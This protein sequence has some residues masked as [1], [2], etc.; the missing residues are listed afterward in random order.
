MT[1]LLTMTTTHE[2]PFQEKDVACIEKGN[3]I[4]LLTRK[5][6]E[7]EQELK[8]VKT[9]KERRRDTVGQQGEE[10]RRCR[11]ENLRLQQLLQTANNNIE[12]RCFVDGTN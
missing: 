1:Q 4:G 11:E 5:L 2:F 12:N 6:K 3:E 9:E 8:K 7:T 10:L